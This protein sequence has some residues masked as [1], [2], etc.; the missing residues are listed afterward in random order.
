MSGRALLLSDN[1][2]LLEQGVALLESLDDALF[3]KAE[4]LVSESGIGSHVRHCV[5]YYRCFLG[6]LAGGRVD[7]D[8]RERDVRIETDRAHALERLSRLVGELARVADAA[9]QE[10]R[11]KMDSGLEDEANAPWSSSSVERELHF[12]MSHTVHHFA[13]IA[14]ILRANG[15]VPPD[16]FGVAPSTLRYWEEK[17]ACAR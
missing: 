1:V 5:D 10:L 17:R 14:V 12:L 11:V 6:G 9:E 4:P 3:A 2:R 15:V 8:R 13:L 16:D 7:F